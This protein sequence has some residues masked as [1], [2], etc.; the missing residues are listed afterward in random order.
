MFTDH[1][2]C[3]CDGTFKENCDPSRA[4]TDVADLLSSQGADDTLSFMDEVRLLPLYSMQDVQ[5][6]L[7]TVLGGTYTGCCVRRGLLRNSQTVS[8]PV[9]P[10][11]FS[12]SLGTSF[13]PSACR[14][15]SCL[16]AAHPVT[17][18]GV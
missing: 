12:H 8:R 2:H 18:I 6:D 4:Y 9:L 1:A 16:R 10:S 3:S 15:M 11:T 13:P 14:G 5:T 17:N 7:S